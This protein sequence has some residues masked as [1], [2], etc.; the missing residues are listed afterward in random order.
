MFVWLWATFLVYTRAWVVLFVVNQDLRMTRE[1]EAIKKAVPS[2]A[3]VEAL[4]SASINKVRHC[5]ACL[6]WR[7]IG[8]WF[9]LT[10]TPGSNVAVSMFECQSFRQGIH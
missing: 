2:W 4:A 5:F 8:F 6:D 3:T 10:T 7:K 9:V 1:Q